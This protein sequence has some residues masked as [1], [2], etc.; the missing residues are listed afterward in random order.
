MW[1]KPTT[2][3]A[4]VPE[5]YMLLASKHKCSLKLLTS[6]GIFLLTLPVASV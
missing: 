5:Q 2:E 6:C 3:S 4:V 1:E